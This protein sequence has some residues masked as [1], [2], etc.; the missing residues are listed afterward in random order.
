MCFNSPSFLPLPPA[1]NT[2]FQTGKSCVSIPEMK[3]MYAT[4]APKQEMQVA[5][6]TRKE[7]GAPRER[8]AT[9]VVGM[10]GK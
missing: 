4:Q 6:L 5:A 8:A 10:D 2:S 1:H 3:I 9:W 7:A